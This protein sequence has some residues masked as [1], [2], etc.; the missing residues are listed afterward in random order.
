MGFFNKLLKAGPAMNRLAKAFDECLNSIA[1]FHTTKDINEIYKAAWIFNYGVINSL[2]KWHW[3]T[4]ITKIMIPNHYELGRITISQASILILNQISTVTH[5]LDISQIVE[6]ILEG[7]KEFQDK[8][9]LVSQN[10]KN[11]IK[12]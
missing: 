8:S 1:L 5:Q 11:K 10:I 2:E 9:Y 6:D 3:N 4:V 12:P 7:G